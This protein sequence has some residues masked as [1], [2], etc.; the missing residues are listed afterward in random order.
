M[1]SC[2]PSC[3]E[4]EFRT[5]QLLETA[6]C[7]RV[8]D[9]PGDALADGEDLGDLKH[10]LRDALQA[11]TKMI[12]EARGAGPERRGGEEEERDQEEEEK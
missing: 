11:P 6:E 5:R 4:V 8:R 2:D 3:G 9:G 12:A 10:R 7:A 1:I